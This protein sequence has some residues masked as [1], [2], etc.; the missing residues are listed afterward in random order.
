[1][2]VRKNCVRG[3]GSRDLAH[4]STD[5]SI[6]ASWNGGLARPRREA[7][8]GQDLSTAK[9]ISFPERCGRH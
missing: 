9:R 4:G 3:T 7:D 5:S 1:M 2:E 6:D 8:F